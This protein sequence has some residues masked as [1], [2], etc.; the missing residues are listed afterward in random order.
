MTRTTILDFV[1]KTIWKTRK[2][3]FFGAI[4]V[5]FRARSINFSG[6]VALLASSQRY[7]RTFMKLL[8]SSPVTRHRKSISDH[9]VFPLTRSIKIQ[10]WQFSKHLLQI[11]FVA[12]E[13]IYGQLSEMMLWDTLRH[14]FQHATCSSIDWWEY[15]LPL[16]VKSLQQSGMK[17]KEK[18]CNYD[19]VK[20]LKQQLKKMQQLH[21]DD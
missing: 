7:A 9:F 10:A 15:F 5:L 21:S 8:I 16:F 14:F 11:N 12:L 2:S 4:K 3:T 18:L 13:E 6:S 20:S 19:I 17:W 1:W